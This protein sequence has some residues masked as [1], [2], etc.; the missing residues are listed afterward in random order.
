M[1]TQIM[2]SL[3][4][5]MFGVLFGF[6]A[7]GFVF[8]PLL[9]NASVL[10]RPPN[11]LGLVGYWS[12]NEGTSTIATDF[13]GNGNRGVLTNIANPPTATSGWT[14]GKLGKALNFDGVNDYVDGQSGSSLD[15]LVPLTASLWIYPYSE[16]GGGEGRLIGKVASAAAGWNVRFCITCTNAIELL[17][18]FATTNLVRTMSNNL[19]T[20]NTWQHILVTWDG[21][22][23][24]SNANIYVN[25]VEVSYQT[26]TNGAGGKNND[27]TQ[28]LFIG[29]NFDAAKTFN[30]LIDEVRIY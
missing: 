23:N 11:N 19:I 1:K 17:G 22:S 9:A 13:S 29:T 6:C 7:L 4:I 14:N 21:S 10:A 25:G 5:K 27:N 12:F 24:A 16:G 8:W 26:T 30:G 3:K 28:N 18:G 15:N 2:Q 20:L